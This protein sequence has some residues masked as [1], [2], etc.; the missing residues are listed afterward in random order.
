MIFPEVNPG[1]GEAWAKAMAWHNL[2]VPESLGPGPRPRMH[3]KGLLS[4]W[5]AGFQGAWKGHTQFWGVRNKGRECG[6]DEHW[7]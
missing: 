2:Y 1:H 7:G 6:E 5:R 3:G 4:C